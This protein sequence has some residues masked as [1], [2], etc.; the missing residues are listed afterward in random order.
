LL[1]STFQLTRQF[2]QV[3]QIRKSNNR[4]NVKQVSVDEHVTVEDQAYSINDN[5][6]FKPEESIE[7]GKQDRFCKSICSHI[8][9]ST[10][11]RGQIEKEITPQIIANTVDR[12]KNERTVLDYLTECF[13]PKAKTVDLLVPERPDGPSSHP[14]GGLQRLHKRHDA[15]PRR[16][17]QRV[18]CRR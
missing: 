10:D 6:E 18:Q 4:K 5:S 1:S 12:V 7:I 9:R 11:I 8:K 16:D 3:K 17:H 13:V 15:Q 2:L 14:Y